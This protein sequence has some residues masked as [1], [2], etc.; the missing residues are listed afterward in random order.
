MLS[1]IGPSSDLAPFVRS[2]KPA[3]L[4][5]W[6]RHARRDPKAQELSRE[7]LRNHVPELLDE[8]ASE[9][10]LALGV[11][12]TAALDRYARAHA[13]QRLD[14]GFSL[15]DLVREYGMLRDAI[16]AEVE[17][18]QL[19]LTTRE[20]ALLDSILDHTIERAVMAY[21]SAQQRTLL[22]L[23][24]ISDAAGEDGDVERLLQRL[25]E[26]F[27][28]TAEGIDEVE[29]LLCEGDHLAPRAT[30][31]A[32]DAAAPSWGIAKD[33]VEARHP[34]SATLNGGTPAHADELRERGLRAM[35]A[36]P[37]L[38]RSE[39]SGVVQMGSRTAFDFGE[40][41][42]VLL[43]VVADRATSVI[44]MARATAR[45]RADAAVIRALSQAR[46]VD[47]AMR[48]LVAAIGE[49]FHW[50]TGAF[51]KHDRVSGRLRFDRGWT[52][53]ADDASWFQS[54]NATRTFASNEGLPGRAWATR[55]LVWVPDIA[56]DPSFVRQAEAGRARLNTGLAFPLFDDAGDPLG[57]L[58]FF[59]RRRRSAHE[60]AVQL[61]RVL[62]RQV[63]DFIRRI[64]A[65]ERVRKSEA[66]LSAMQRSALDAIV[67]M[68]HEGLVT[69]WNP[70]AETTFGYRPED[71]MGRAVAN[72]IIPEAL[73]DAHRKGLARY[74][75]SGEQK[76][77][78]QRI[79]MPAIDAT[80]REFPIE[81][82]ISA[83][84]ADPP[85]FV[86]FAR[87]ISARKTLEVDRQRLLEEA[88][89][90]TAAR[91]LLLAVVSHDLRNS[92]NAVVISG[93]TMQ[94]ALARV[95]IDERLASK[96]LQTILRAANQMRQLI[97]DLLDVAVMQSGRLSIEP[98][99]QNVCS[100]VTEAVDLHRPLAEEKGI[101]LEEPDIPDEVWIDGD[102]GRLQQ[103]LGNLLGNAI[104]FGRR[105]DTVRVSGRLEDH[106]ICIA[107]AD[108]GPGI[109]ADV[110]PK[111]F[112][113]HWAGQMAGKG[114]GLGLFISR[115][116][117]EAHGG[118]L[119]AESGASG[120]STFTFCVPRS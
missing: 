118:R 61:T 57:V 119:W 40:E 80:G 54:T 22:A 71:V 87:D 60:E 111:I 79:E 98:T 34:V 88:Q 46:T 8:I 31:R 90:A 32:A 25:S 1:S 59:T 55:A 73:R 76:Y 21:S 109:A 4:Q 92:L 95:P 14:R 42:R 50:D 117:I 37:L 120:G 104:K 44:E 101:R 30:T 12:Q 115:R 82:T 63:P 36:V 70:A 85:V 38:Y 83:V 29:I 97:G 78:N 116:L 26:I 84:D 91:D 93:A 51:W 58:E 33:A 47:D 114:T 13:T 74:L 16:W 105:G 23:T 6:E 20:C 52:L 19:M 69:S 7:A 86:G 113:P 66:I 96:T 5:R 68:D 72:L 94:M 48:S 15:G 107:I 35:Y 9:A 102:R 64:A 2:A 110:L 99:R 75:R 10:E 28:Q 11:T 112:E 81:L 65:A 62:A 27:A 24:R 3:I 89:N 45:D 49:L 43:R 106:S 77:L 100:I 18:A 17:H 53:T 103:V 108:T 39:I 41:H 56:S 67:W